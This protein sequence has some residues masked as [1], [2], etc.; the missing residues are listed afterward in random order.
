MT[1]PATVGAF[2]IVLSNDL[3]AAQP[4]WERLGFERTGGD[5]NYL[6]MTG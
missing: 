2:A 5:A 6:I 4:F 1:T 3:A